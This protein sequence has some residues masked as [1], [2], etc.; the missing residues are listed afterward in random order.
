MY[1]VEIIGKAT[2]VKVECYTQHPIQF[3]P[4]SFLELEVKLNAL[5]VVCASFPFSIYDDDCCR[6]ELVAQTQKRK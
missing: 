1:Q 3:S 2:Y 6:L 4:F 5:L